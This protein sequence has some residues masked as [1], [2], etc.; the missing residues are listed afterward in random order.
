[1]I[2]VFASLFAMHGLGIETGDP[3]KTGVAL[4]V[5]VVVGDAGRRWR[6]RG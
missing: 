1:M 4:V 5:T 2:G 3:A 6:C